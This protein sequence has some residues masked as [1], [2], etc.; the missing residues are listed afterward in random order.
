METK[1]KIGNKVKIRH[2]VA[3][4]WTGIVWTIEKFLT[5]NVEMTR[6]GSPKPMRCPPHLLVPADTP[7][8]PAGHG[9]IDGS[10]MTTMTTTTFEPP[11][12]IGTLV[13]Y[14][15]G[16]HGGAY[17]VMAMR[18][19]GRYRIVKLGGDGGRYFT[20]VNRAHL[21]VVD[22]DGIFRPKN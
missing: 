4:K 3:G 2:D 12:V 1:F 15:N 11:L 21:T 13:M 17:V 20:N 19:N 14:K 22:F 9:H 5:K 7:D 8:L 18:T 10:A 6:E 16:T